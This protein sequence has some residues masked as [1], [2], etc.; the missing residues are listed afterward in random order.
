MSLMSASASVTCPKSNLDFGI[1]VDQPGKGVATQTFRLLLEVVGVI[2][3]NL[4]LK[5]AN[6]GTILVGS[7]IG[8]TCLVTARKWFQGRK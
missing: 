1:I 8:L 4:E 6:R 3:Q 2:F 7:A 5:R